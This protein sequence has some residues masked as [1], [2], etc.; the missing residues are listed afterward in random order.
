[1]K[2]NVLNTY[3]RYGKTSTIVISSIELGENK[4]QTK[5]TCGFDSQQKKIRLNF[6]KA[7]TQGRRRVGNNNNNFCVFLGKNELLWLSFHKK[8]VIK[9]WLVVRKGIFVNGRLYNFVVW[10]V[11][12]GIRIQGVPFEIIQKY[13]DVALKQSIFDLTL[14]KPKRV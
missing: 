8:I 4:T 3:T 10:L 1:M 7:K 2:C 12:S 5:V 14:M 6:N 13:K 9:T 11:S